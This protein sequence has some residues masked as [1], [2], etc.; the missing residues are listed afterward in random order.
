[1]LKSLTVIQRDAYSWGVR[2]GGLRGLL[3]GQESVG[4]PGRRWVALDY[5]SPRLLW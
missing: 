5:N 3:G 4:C 1:M 2:D